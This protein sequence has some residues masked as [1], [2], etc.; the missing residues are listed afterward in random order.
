MIKKGYLFSLVVFCSLFFLTACPKAQGPS[1]PELLKF[2]EQDVPFDT[3][4]EV[5]F[6]PETIRLP[7][8]YIND[9]IES[10]AKKLSYD[11]YYYRLKL[12]EEFKKV[13]D[14]MVFNPALIFQTTTISEEDAGLDSKA[15]ISYDKL[16]K[17]NGGGDICVGTKFV[18]GL[19]VK[20][21]S[22]NLVYHAM[23]PRTVWAPA[24]S[25]EGGNGTISVPGNQLGFGNGVA[26]E[27]GG[28]ITHASTVYKDGKTTYTV[29]GATG[30]YIS[31]RFGD[32]GS[33]NKVLVK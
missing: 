15:K 14:E 2:K 11:F 18:L 4:K 33:T 25:A 16:K 32:F 3:L 22:D 17:A 1:E 12:D 6:V 9:K 24:S 21:Q 13:T 20:D 28:T 31:L 7:D 30:L 23:M 26:C 8:S 29:T 19:K 5:G 10:K 27:G